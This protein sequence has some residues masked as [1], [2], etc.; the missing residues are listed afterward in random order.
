M[1]RRS[2][3]I[4][5]GMPKEL[6]KGAVDIG[7]GNNNEEKKEHIVAGSVELKGKQAKEF[8]K[9]LKELEVK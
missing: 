9:F 3:L 6:I 7:L 8:M 5:N 4:D 2:D 1:F